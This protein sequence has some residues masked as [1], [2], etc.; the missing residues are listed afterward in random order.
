MA[1][2]QSPEGIRSGAFGETE[3]SFPAA[4]FL[5]KVEPLPPRPSGSSF[6]YGNQLDHLTHKPRP[7]GGV[8]PLQPRNGRGLEL[9]PLGWLRS[10]PLS[11]GLPHQPRCRRLARRS[12][13]PGFAPVGPVGRGPAPDSP[14]EPQGVWLARRV[15]CR[16][17]WRSSAA[18]RNVW[19]FSSNQRN[20]HEQ[21][22]GARAGPA[23][24]AC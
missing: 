12:G 5:S 17:S 15:D 13:L 21:I 18:N 24:R 20:E 9:G 19:N 3:Q 4:G 10:D 2:T 1:R 8:E 16:T 22:P 14:G 23:S 11:P 7:L 6:C